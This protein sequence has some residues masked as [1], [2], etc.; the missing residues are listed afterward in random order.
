MRFEEFK[1][2]LDWWSNRTENEQAWKVDFKQKYAEAIT[3]ANPR[4][5]AADKAKSRARRY[6][7]AKNSKAAAKQWQICKDEQAKA[8][9]IYWTIYNLDLKNPALDKAE[10]HREPEEIVQS[11]IDKENAILNIV[12]EI[13]SIIEEGYE[14]L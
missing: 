10:V 5:E 1:P 13:T 14:K 6:E 7:K 8:D 9:A 3:E 11:I 12:S 4:Y 2:V